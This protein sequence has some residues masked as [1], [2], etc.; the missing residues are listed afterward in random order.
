MEEDKSMGAERT[1]RRGFTLIELLIVIGIIAI[2]ATAVILILNPAELLR[3]ARDSQR[4]SDLDTLR[5][6]LA[7]YS[8]TTGLNLGGLVGSCYYYS[9]AALPI[10]PSANCGG[11]HAGRT[12]SAVGSLAVDGTGWVPTNLNSIP[13]GA[14]LSV[15]PKDPRNTSTLFYSYATNGVDLYEI[16]ADMES[17]RYSQGGADDVESTDGGNMAGI[18]EVG[19]APNLG[20]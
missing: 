3:Q 9:P 19:N 18:R 13:G 1:Y 7:L 16:N 8:A 5:G 12:N 4:I 6:A 15:L 2:L 20:Y 17:G 14:P 10:S 11:R